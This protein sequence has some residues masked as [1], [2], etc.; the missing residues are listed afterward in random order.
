LLE[1][2]DLLVELR[3]GGALWLTLNRPEVFN[4]FGGEL[5]V[6]LAER[7]EDAASNDDVRVVVLTG[8]GPAFSAGADISGAAAPARFDVRALDAAN[9]IVRAI[10]AC[11]KP[12][13]AAV[14]GVAAG[15]GC[16]TALAADLA[17]AAKSATF[18]LAFARIGLMPDG[19]A[20]ATVPAA[21]G[22][23]R[24]M[25]MALLDEP[26][27]AQE[28]YDAGL[29]SHLASDEEF[30]AL[31][32]KLVRRLSQGA[33]LAQAATKKAVNAATLTQLEPALERE[34][35]GQTVLL[36][37]DDVA[38]GMRAFNEQRRP[39]FTGG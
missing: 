35:T 7:L 14:N 13:V 32:E 39:R 16:S 12:V 21:I 27:T 2:D 20:S 34:R 19:G 38:E 11:P 25:R 30:P 33:P 28:A 36:R 1:T 4:A 3:E 10:T 15:V 6:A 22:R 18:L 29:V 8:T 9:R 37:T 5:A 17:V 26:L 24:A 23:A 31:V